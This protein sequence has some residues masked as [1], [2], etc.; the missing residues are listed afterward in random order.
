MIADH[1]ADLLLRRQDSNLDHRNQDSVRASGDQA[2]AQVKALSAFGVDRFEA[3]SIARIDVSLDVRGAARMA[4]RHAP[5]SAP[6]R[7]SGIDQPGLAAA[8]LATADLGDSTSRERWEG[9][10]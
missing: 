4:R 10:P 6:L 2:F 1:G 8:T 9:D 5:L 7:R 3:R